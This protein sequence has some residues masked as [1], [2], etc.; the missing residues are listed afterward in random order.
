MKNVII[1]NKVNIDKFGGKINDY[2][3]EKYLK[4]QVENSL[5]FGWNLADIIIATNFSFE[6]MGVKNVELKD[7]CNFSGFNNKWYGIRELY[8]NHFKEDCW[9]HDYDNWQIS[10][11]KEFPTFN[12]KLAGCTYV[13]TEEWNTA[14]LFFKSNCEDILN[15]I[16]D[17]LKMN[18]NIKFD[19]DENAIAVL[20][21][22]NEVKSYFSTIDNKYN[23]GLTKLE[24]RYNAATKPVCSLGVKILNKGSYEN[25]INKY[26]DFNLIPKHLDDIIKKYKE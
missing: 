25:F 8:Q 16:Y 9:L 1:Y 10:D 21:R 7:I 18:E 13:F 11:I 23:V 15:Y 17:F 3:I 26:K 4:A 12:G 2:I 14:S 5:H 20:R 24:H 22:V 6:Y 19:S